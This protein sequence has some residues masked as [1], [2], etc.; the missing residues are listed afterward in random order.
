MRSATVVVAHVLYWIRLC[1]EVLDALTL[2]SAFVKLPHIFEWP[3]LYDPLRA[4]VIP[5]ACASFRSTLPPSTQLS[6][7]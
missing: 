2:A 3:L 1:V 7:N 4:A 5:V 6:M